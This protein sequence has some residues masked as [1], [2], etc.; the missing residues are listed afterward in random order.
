MLVL[1]ERL[2]VGAVSLSLFSCSAIGDVGAAASFSVLT[3]K[4]LAKLVYGVV[5]DVSLE[6]FENGVIARRNFRFLRDDLPVP[7]ILIRY[8]SN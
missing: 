4:S 5:E 1:V 8:W 7:S 2:V 6:E 3:S